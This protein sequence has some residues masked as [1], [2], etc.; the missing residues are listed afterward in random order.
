MRDGVSLGTVIIEPLN[1]EIPAPI[2]LMRTPFAIDWENSV[3]RLFDTAWKELSE[4]GYIFVLQ[5]IRGR[6][7]SEGRYVLY[8]GVRDTTK[9]GTVD[10][11]TDS[12]DTI[13]WLINQVPNNNGRVG[14]M[15]GSHPGT[16]AAL[17]LLEP[18]PALQAVSPQAPALNQFI[19]D[20]FFHYGAFSLAPNYEYAQW[21]YWAERSP[22]PPRRDLVGYDYNDLYEFFLRN[23]PISKINEKIFKDRFWIWNELIEHPTLDDYWRTREL[24]MLITEASVPT[25]IVG[26]WYDVQDQY[27][28]FGLYRSLNRTDHDGQV[29]LVIGPWLHNEW[30]RA[31]DG[32]RA[33]LDFDFGSATAEY[34]RRDLLGRF[35]SKYLWQR[36][37]KELAEITFFQTGSNRWKSYDALPSRSVKKRRLYFAADGKLHFDRAPV[38]NNVYDTYIADPNNPVPHAPRPLPKYYSEKGQLWRLMDQRFA[39]MRPDVAGYETE[40]LE[41]DVIVTGDITANLFAATEGT[42]ADWVVKLIDVY[43]QEY[44]QNP[45]LAGYHYLV[46]GEIFRAKFRNSFSL[47]EA[48]TPNRAEQYRIDLLPRDHVFKKGHRIRVQVQGSWFPLFDANPGSFVNIMQ[49]TQQDFIRTEHRIYRSEEQPSHIELFTLER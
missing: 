8:R 9:P 31:K 3:T 45:K 6:F 28:P 22:E 48:L 7:R 42:D 2:I 14:I 20:D 34:Y 23:T 16:L 39:T 36:D 10:D 21:S 27:G 32:G 24:D 41:Q 13:E 1:S 46:S 26:G 30:M 11:A 47:P 49:A 43:P 29:R 37:E 40:V 17:S 19:G 35:F 12:Y 38:K 33:L 15:G 18:H 5:N 44:P 4:E 25:L